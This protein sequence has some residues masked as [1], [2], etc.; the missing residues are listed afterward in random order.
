MIDYATPLK[1][2]RQ[3]KRQRIARNIGTI[4]VEFVALS[5]FLVGLLAIAI[6]IN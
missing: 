4:A 3:E 2:M 5:A 6:V 1:D